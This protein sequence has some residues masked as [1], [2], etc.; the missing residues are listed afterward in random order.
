MKRK[1]V[2]L[3]LLAAIIFCVVG[4]LGFQ[5]LM[6]KSTQSSGVEV[7]VVTPIQSSFNEAAI[8]RLQDRVDA[9][10]SYVAPN[11][12]TGLNNPTPFGAF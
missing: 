7:E 5:A 2:G 1:D 6:P 8:K 4:Y 3:I 10:D 11:L 12:T 9:E